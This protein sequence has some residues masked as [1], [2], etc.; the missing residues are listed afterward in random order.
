MRLSQNNVAVLKRK[1]TMIIG[2]YLDFQLE[3]PHNI[4][5]DFFETLLMFAKCSR[6]S[7][8]RRCVLLEDGN[9][10]LTPSP[11]KEKFTG[12]TNTTIL[13]LKYV[14]RYCYRSP[15]SNSLI[16]SSLGHLQLDG[17]IIG[18]LARAMEQDSA[19]KEFQLAGNTNMKTDL[20]P[21]FLREQQLQ[22]VLLSGY[23]MSIQ[24]ASLH[25]L[26]YKN[27]EKRLE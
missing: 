25:L 26:C 23:R 14:Y 6:V 1:S 17:L 16:S 8:G 24:E 20:S 13:K 15:I 4:K 27:H 12:H 19:M 22:R 21:I 7:F 2:L 3:V 11:I 10:P 9:L 18:R 5:Q